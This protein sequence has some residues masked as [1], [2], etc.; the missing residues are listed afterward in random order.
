MI[1]CPNVEMRDRLPDLANESLE[2]AV[3]EL[4]LVHL[5]ECTACTAEIE[6][7]RTTRLIMLKTTPK[8]NVAGIVMALPS[9]DSVSRAE[10][11]GRAVPQS[12]P[13]KSWANSWRV[14]AAVAFLAAGIGSF[15]LL[16][17]SSAVRAP[18]SMAAAGQDTV[19]GLAL[20]GA[21]ADLSDDELS[22]L[23]TDIAKIEALPSTEVEPA[24]SISVP[25]ILP[26]SITRELEIE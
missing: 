10:R 17:K 26:D 21:L 6:I 12:L 9:Y 8:V 7:L 11:S 23:A 16:N 15:E 4:V 1:D 13:R 19:V 3:R 14:A 22:T 24:R 5:A 18:D 20:T 2:P 25:A